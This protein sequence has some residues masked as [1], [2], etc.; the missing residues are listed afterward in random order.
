MLSNNDVQLF[1]KLLD[2]LSSSLKE[3]AIKYELIVRASDSNAEA[4]SD[5]AKDMSCVSRDIEK[6]GVSVRGAKD[7]SASDTKSM[8]E[9]IA[10]CIKEINDIREVLGKVT[11]TRLAETE[12]AI[13]VDRMLKHV[14]SHIDSNCVEMAR[15]GSK[16]LEV[17]ESTKGLGEME[18]SVREMREVVV[19]V[20]LVV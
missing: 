4:M 19:P 16:I 10:R 8:N 14:D 1:Y 5:M 2:S 7:Q 9:S 13:E 18:K 17:A 3:L 20:A 11:E 12:R 6:V 15:V